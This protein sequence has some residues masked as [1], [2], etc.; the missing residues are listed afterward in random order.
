[1]SGECVLAGLYPPDEDH[2]RKDLLVTI[3]CVYCY[4]NLNLV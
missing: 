3:I 2:V 1:M 4:R